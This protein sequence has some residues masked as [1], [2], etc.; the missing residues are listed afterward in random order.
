MPIY[1]GTNDGMGDKRETIPVK[2][3]VRYLGAFSG[4]QDILPGSSQMR[5]A[6]WQP[7]KSAWF[8]HAW[9][10]ICAATSSVYAAASMPEYNAS[11]ATRFWLSLALWYRCRRP[12]FSPGASAC[13]EHPCPVC[14]MLV[15]ANE[16]AHAESDSVRLFFCGRVVH[17][18]HSAAK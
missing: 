8:T 9:P 5:R 17:Q 1:T 10:K 15:F 18:M 12:V 14:G 16:F 7:T 6:G 4:A 3:T 13:S 2:Q 11:I